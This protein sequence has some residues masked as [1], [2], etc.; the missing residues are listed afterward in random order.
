[1]SH[2]TFGYDLEQD[3][4]WMMYAD[5]Q[6]RIW[7]TRHIAQGIVGAL[8]TLIEQTAVGVANDMPAKRA[9]MEHRMAVRETPDG[10][11][12]QYPYQVRIESKESLYAQGFVLC[13]TLNA[14]INSGGGFIKFISDQ[15]E[16]KFD[17][18]RYDLHVWL[19]AFRMVVS[20]AKWNLNPALPTWLDEPLLPTSIQKLLS[21][22][23]PSDLDP[24]DA[25]S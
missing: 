8:P 14:E 12:R 19:R 17:F 3:R 22:P 15:G 23:L 10:G 9:E 11:T 4:L 24:P 13:K 2:T 21:E 25:S 1:M 6:P 20:D 5:D 7:M 18:N 16:I